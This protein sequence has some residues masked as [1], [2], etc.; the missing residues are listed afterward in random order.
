MQATGCVRPAAS[1]GAQAWPQ[2][3]PQSLLWGFCL[4]CL[5]QVT[6]YENGPLELGLRR[7]CHPFLLGCEPGPSHLG[8]WVGPLPTDTSRGAS[9]LLSAPLVLPSSECLL[10]SHHLSGAL[11]ASSLCSVK[12]LG[13]TLLTSNRP[14]AAPHFPLSSDSEDL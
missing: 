7:P 5:T 1:P 12:G 10:F 4:A 14:P 11:P 6:S 2:P 9:M 8:P 3:F 13:Y